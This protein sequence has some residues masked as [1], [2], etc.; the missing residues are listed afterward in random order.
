M[1]SNTAAAGEAAPLGAVSD[2]WEDIGKTSSVRRSG[3]LMNDANR[4][5][6]EVQQRGVEEFLREYGFQLTYMYV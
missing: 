1:E 6:A 5:T 4:E 2:R 3:S